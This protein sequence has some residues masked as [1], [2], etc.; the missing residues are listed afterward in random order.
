M[1]QTRTVCFGDCQALKGVVLKYKNGNY[2]YTF[3]HCKKLEDGGIKV[4]LRTM[5]TTPLRMLLMQ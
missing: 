1:S 2:N 3:E 4:P 5:M